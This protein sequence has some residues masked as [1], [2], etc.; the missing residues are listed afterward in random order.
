VPLTVQL[1]NGTAMQTAT[2]NIA[3]PAEGLWEIDVE[4]NLTTSGLEFTQ[5]LAGDVLP[6]APA[7]TSPTTGSNATD[8]TPTVSG[9]GAP[10][11]TVTVVDGNGDVLCTDVVADDGTW[12]CA[13]STLPAGPTTVTATQADSSGDPSPVSNSV[14]VNVPS[15][16][17]V[18]LGI[19]PSAPALDQPVVLTATTTG[20][21]DGVVVTFLDGNASLG[22]GTV[23]SGTATL[24]LPDGLGVGDHALTASVP[25]TDSSEA[26]TSNEVDVSIGKTAS[27]I[28]LSLDSSSVAYG[29]AGSGSVAV[30]GATSG[31]ATVTYGSTD[32]SVPIDSSGNGTFT[33][34]ANL[35]VG[36]HQISA[37][38]NGT[39]TVAASNTATATLAVTKAS[40]KTSLTLSKTTVK[41]GKLETVTVRVSGHAGGIYPAGT[42][43]VKAKVGSKSTTRSAI[44]GQAGAGKKVITIRLPNKV[45]KGT[46]VAHFAGS[47]DFTASSSTARKVKTT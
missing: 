18:S 12:S 42:I 6:Q 38:Y 35:S 25:A 40:T 2:A 27:T 23:A 44:L 41:H 17:S 47:A 11:D 46:V 29:H 22:T 28:A 43:T 1:V 33:L 31:T 16:T 45:G 5:T 4:Q 10:G 36:A 14:I 32:I 15:A 13:T 37:E 7:I 8:M 39:D 26:S 30:S 24:S 3:N 9:T 21:D 34:P 20:V 19:D